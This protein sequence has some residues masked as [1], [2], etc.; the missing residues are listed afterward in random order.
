[1]SHTFKN[2]LNFVDHSDAH[3]RSS[4]ESHIPF[5]KFYFTSSSQSCLINWYDYIRRENF[6]ILKK[7][8]K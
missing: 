1:M 6:T 4:T 8:L 3:E 7:Q 2:K 5:A